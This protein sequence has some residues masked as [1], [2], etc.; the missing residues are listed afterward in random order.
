MRKLVHLKVCTDIGGFNS[1]VSSILTQSL[2][3]AGSDY[4]KLNDTELACDYKKF[5]KWVAMEDKWHSMFASKA[6]HHSNKVQ[7]LASVYMRY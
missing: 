6:E 5:Y 2:T 1:L 4:N 7:V 3:A